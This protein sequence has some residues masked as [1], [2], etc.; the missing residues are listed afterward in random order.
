[1]TGASVLMEAAAGFIWPAVS[2]L[3]YILSPEYFPSQRLGQRRCG[4]EVACPDDGALQ[5]R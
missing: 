2:E 5:V 1:M 4:S 3:R